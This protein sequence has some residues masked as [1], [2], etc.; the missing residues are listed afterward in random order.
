MNAIAK[1]PVS[2]LAMVNQ[3]KAGIA[4]VQ[5]TLVKTAGDPYMRFQ[6]DGTWVY[7]QDDT[8]VQE[9]SLW[10]LNPMSIQHGWVA[11]KRGEKVD[12]SGG[13]L[14]QIM[15]PATQPKPSEMDLPELSDKSGQWVQQYA[16]TMLCMTG[17][18]KGEQTLWKT[19]SKGGVDAFDKLLK[20]IGIQLDA[21]VTKPVPVVQLLSDSYKNRT[22]G[23]NTYTP[24]LKVVQWIEMSESLPDLGMGAEE[25]EQ[26]TPEP[27]KAAEPAK[28]TRKASVPAV[29]AETA[30]LDE[31]PEI[32]A[33]MAEIAARKA[34]KDKAATV[35][36]DPAAAAKAARIAELKALMEA[37]ETGDDEQ[38]EVAVAAPAAAGEPIRRRQ[39]P[40]A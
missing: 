10:A 30:T 20:A 34:A 32:A 25:A 3:L 2:M 38:V 15:V 28:R 14:G 9:G 6:R 31:D 19:N 21:D 23:G 29:K 35:A 16:V 39:R 24:E 12:N 36:V 7:G 22:Y 1:T 27:E 18:D 37:E 11:W 26:A 5:R 33:M 13:P 40:A 8:E 4:N 17:E